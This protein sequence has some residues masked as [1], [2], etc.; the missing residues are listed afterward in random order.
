MLYLS[1]QSKFT[2]EFLQLPLQLPLQVL[3]LLP[4]VV[5]FAV[6][7]AVA[8]R[9]GV[10]TAMLSAHCLDARQGAPHPWSRAWLLQESMHVSG[11]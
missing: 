11:L 1:L 8:S 3:I 5:Q 9:Q 2:I 4:L 7:V 10:Q 6:L